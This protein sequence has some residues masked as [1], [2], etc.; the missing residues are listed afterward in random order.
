MCLR[1]TESFLSFVWSIF[2][3]SCV[4]LSSTDCGCN[5]CFNLVP[6]SCHYYRVHVQKL[7]V[8]HTLHYVIAGWKKKTVLCYRIHI[9][10]ACSE[11]FLSLPSSCT[12][13]LELFFPFNDGRKMCPIL[14][15]YCIQ[16]LFSYDY[17]GYTVI[18][19]NFIFVLL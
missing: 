7:S 17:P 4:I 5:Q 9:E 19:I 18:Y 13:V 11:A 3:Y 6:V 14:F 15:F 16:Q 1:P 2:H 12:L 10:F 8:F